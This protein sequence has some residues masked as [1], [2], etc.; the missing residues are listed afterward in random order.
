MTNLPTLKQVQN[1]VS[2]ER[3]ETSGPITDVQLQ[4]YCDKAANVPESLDEPFVFGWK[5]EAP[6]RFF[7]MWT[8]RRLLDLQ[9]AQSLLQV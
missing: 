5:Y 6:D 7:V 1:F 3:S 8:T 4:A 2:R 9:K